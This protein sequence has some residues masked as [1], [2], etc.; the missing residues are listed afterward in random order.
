MVESAWHNKTRLDIVEF[1]NN[2]GYYVDTSHGEGAVPLY[3]EK[4]SKATYLAD[5]DMLV[6]DQERVKYII[7]IH[8]KKLR[9]LLEDPSHSK[10]MSFFFHK[11]GILASIYSLS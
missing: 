8:D 5:V 10:R 4:V 2:K 1:Y 11:L 7:E 9:F 3:F 6:M